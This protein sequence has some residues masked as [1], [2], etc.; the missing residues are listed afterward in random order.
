MFPPGSLHW[1]FLL[2]LVKLQKMEL[3]LSMVFSV[4]LLLP[5]SAP[6][7]SSSCSCSSSSS[8][9]LLLLAVVVIHH[10]DNV[11]VGWMKVGDQKSYTNNQPQRHHCCHNDPW[12]LHTHSLS[13][14][15]FTI[16]TRVVLYTRS[17]T[18]PSPLS[19]G[20]LAGRSSLSAVSSPAFSL[21]PRSPRCSKPSSKLTWQAAQ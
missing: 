11:L 4:N 2:L 15:C 7:V 5:H 21:S 10:L 9:L 17:S 6:S 18:T 1:T 12:P 8:L 16:F 13:Q 20:R 19:T 3:K 14:S